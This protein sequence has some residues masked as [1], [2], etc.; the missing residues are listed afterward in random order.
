M[1]E[2]KMHSALFNNPETGSDNYKTKPE[3][4][5]GI[6]K[7]VQQWEQ[8]VFADIE[9]KYFLEYHNRFLE[10]KRYQETI[11]DEESSKAFRDKCRNFSRRVVNYNDK[12]REWYNLL[13]KTL[14]DNKYFEWKSDK[15][16]AS[17]RRD[18]LAKYGRAMDDV[19][20]KI[21]NASDEEFDN[22]KD[23]LFTKGSDTDL[24]NITYKKLTKSEIYAYNHQD[25]KAYDVEASGE[26]VA[27]GEV[28]DVT[29]R[30][31]LS[32]D[33]PNYLRDIR[34]GKGRWQ[35]L[36]NYLP[37]PLSYSTEKL[38]NEDK[39]AIEDF[40]ESVMRIADKCEGNKDQIKKIEKTLFEIFKKAETNW[41]SNM[42]RYELEQNGFNNLSNR[43]VESVQKVGKFYLET[44]RAE[45][46]S[47][48]HN[49][50]L[51]VMQ[52][53]EKA[54]SC[55]AAVRMF[56]ND[57]KEAKESKA[58]R[59]ANEDWT[60]ILQ[61]ADGGRLH[62]FATK[63]WI[64]DFTAATRLMKMENESFTNR[65]ETDI[66]A[67]LNNDG[68][69]TFADKWI[70]KTWNQFKHIMDSFTP[71]EQQKAWDNLLGHAKLL[72]Q[73]MDLGIRHTE[74]TK[75]D[76]KNW[77]KE[78][79]LLLQNIISQPG[80]DFYTMLKYGPD[81]W[82]EKMKAMLPS[83][84][85]LSKA[86]D[87][88]L[89]NI[90][91]A[92]LPEWVSPTW[93]S[94]AVAGMLYTEYANG[95][96][97]GWQISFDQFVSWLAINSW[98]QVN[99]D[100]DKWWV[101]A[102]ITLSRNPSI[103]LWKG[104]HLRPGA[105]VGF[106][107]LE[108]FSFGGG[109]TVD[110]EWL[111]KNSVMHKIWVWADYTNVLWVC[112]VYTI[113]TWWSRDKL[114]GVES[115]TGKKRDAY[116]NEITKPLFDKLA[117]SDKATLDLENPEIKTIV[118]DYLEKIIN[119][120]LTS[121][122]KSKLKSEDKDVLLA[123]TIRFLSNFNWFDLTQKET[124]DVIAWKMAN[125][126]AL[127]WKDQR[128]QDIDGKAYISSASA[129]FSWVQLW[130]LWVWVLHAGVGISKH[131]LDGYVDGVNN[132][133]VD[134]TPE[135]LKW[136]SEWTQDMVNVL[137]DK[138]GVKDKISLSDKFLVIPAGMIKEGI[139]SINPAMKWLIKKAE[140]GDLLLSPKTV[141]SWPI[142]VNGVAT[143]S[144]EIVIGG[145]DVKSAVRLNASNLEEWKTDG[146]IAEDK[147]TWREVNFGDLW[148]E[149]TFN[150]LKSKLPDNDPLQ[151]VNF[152]DLVKPKTLLVAWQKVVISPFTD[153]QFRAE[154][155][156]DDNPDKS[157][158]HI[159]YKWEQTEKLVSQEIAE[160]TTALYS[161]ISNLKTHA[162]NY[163]KHKNSKVAP[164][165]SE[166]AKLRDDYSQF[167]DFMKG[168]NYEGAAALMVDGTWAG[169]LS[170]M[171]NYI[172]GMEK[173]QILDFT[174][175]KNILS[176]PDTS[177]T[178]KW[179]VLMSIINMFAR[180]RSVEWKWD[181][182]YKFV[183]RV[184]WRPRSF[185][186]IFDAERRWQIEKEIRNSNNLAPDVRDAYIK[187]IESQTVKAR[188]DKANYTKKECHS[189]VLENAIWINL[190][191]SSSV[192][193]PLFNPD[194]YDTF[195][196]R[197]DKTQN[198][199]LHKHALEVV[200]KNPALMN[201]ILKWLN[202]PQDTDLS[203]L[204][205]NYENG[206]LTLDISNKK[207]ILDADLNFGYFAQ[208]VNQMIYLDDISAVIEWTNA[209]VDFGPSVMAW[210][211]TS[212]WTK[213]DLVSSARGQGEVAVTV[214]KQYK[215]DWWSTPWEEEEPIDDP[216]TPD[217]WST[218]G[219]EE[220]DIP[221]D[222][223][224]DKGE[225]TPGDGKDWWK[226]NWDN[227][228]PP[229]VGWDWQSGHQWGNGRWGENNWWTNNSGDE[230]PW[231][232][233]EWNSGH[234]WGNGRN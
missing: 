28:L 154:F 120:K 44:Q 210:G 180:V 71:A 216:K 232:W 225:H 23:N 188:Q 42:Y 18:A 107:P 102:W 204:K 139:V 158:L 190:W 4:P 37:I 218:P 96:W 224:P 17:L 119:E 81:A 10:H 189:S 52:I 195:K 35:Q 53:I 57:V 91:K 66:I 177:S 69:L 152:G 229:N 14:E 29:N 7:D 211:K 36:L 95:V 230:Q 151:K 194:V 179:K 112:N 146:E 77:D 191:D 84:E 70:T 63:L 74:I 50:F 164:Q 1:F 75:E 48:Q 88:L 122:E 213:Q 148:D 13:I 186:N 134:Q 83:P 78:V 27:D 150:Q 61:E 162:L 114:K 85:A 147:L 76:I 2:M 200:A 145:G 201:P 16:K 171:E 206:K 72:N 25:R 170:R 178:D 202:L 82:T 111:N 41:T 182:N 228:Q 207:V 129:W 79:I 12:I 67:D 73:S 31:F 175:I 167:A 38:S 106:T 159:E 116:Y 157:V 6:D 127:K 49:I 196:E 62:A 126:Y 193:N 205:T 222:T 15:Q 43:D 108:H 160:A 109:A 30:K 203:Q 113:K 98:F 183:E 161:Q 47:G 130:I 131:R 223:T 166:L 212:E 34:W 173:G 51:S 234:Q 100:G 215:D 46:G 3:T 231:Q 168:H 9:N 185:G 140:N 5:E 208:C 176:N 93:L 172:N 22:M 94:Q 163:I 115:D 149:T 39:I 142:K 133:Y 132:T 227:T 65:S 104:W 209:S 56:Y 221:W 118:K 55:D 21:R 24:A 233:W 64:K 103:D 33:L 153:W 68:K 124:R 143:Y 40:V 198:E 86:T 92:Q 141:I 219:E 59:K 80:E 137:N 87:E 181:N 192:E 174:Q 220:W 169:M 199:T 89:K 11:V 117:E 214:Y 123:N 45:S 99:K 97:L 90:N 19:Y 54:G 128:L 125:Q 187:L 144:N 184:S 58:D 105:H 165:G 197:L 156:T 8:E 135:E 138:L 155:V 20:N 32:I 101:D 217:W 136:K 226:D 60:N 110:K 121:E 26:K